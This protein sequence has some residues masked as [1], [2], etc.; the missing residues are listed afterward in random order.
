MDN[1]HQKFDSQS[2]A[3]RVRE[4]FLHYGIGKRQ[5]AKELSRILAL[6]F[7]HAHR[8]LKGQSPWTLEQ[9]NSVAAA[10][11][12]TPAAIVDM[13]AEHD[14]PE[15]TMAQDAI[16]FV[17]GVAIPCVGHIGDELAAGRM[18]EFVAL[19]A[20]QQWHIYR[21]EDAP[22]GNCRR[23]E[24]IEIRPGNND[25]ERL[26]I[27]VLDDSHPAADEL[28]K[29]LVSRGFNAVAFYDVS[30][31]CQALQQSLFDGYV[32]DWLI[33][34]ETADKCIEV[35]R[36]SDNP[37]APVLV[38]TGELGTDRRE[39]EIA[40]AMRDYDVL[41]PYEKPVRLHVIEA[42]LQRCFNL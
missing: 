40:K 33:G 28:V 31:F 1:N 15:Q 10:L 37:D 7:S 8:K 5:H 29:Y 4:L 42:A 36:A 3:N 41:G 34:D 26:S 11:G 38:L 9:I 17:G 19:R 27:A 20:E 12:E 39:S 30:S 32:V 13:D 6:S 21:T 22:S 24:L 35:I 2:I 14:T 16:F 23:V 18:S 25:D